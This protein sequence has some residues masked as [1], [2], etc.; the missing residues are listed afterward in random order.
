M[1]SYW[2]QQSF[3]HYDFIVIGAGIVGYNTALFLKAKQ[4]NARICILERGLLP[5][6]AS[7]KNAGFACMGSPTELLADLKT[8]H[9]ESVLQ[10]FE[11]RKNGLDDLRATF[12][13]NNIGYTTN[14]SYE[15]LSSEELYALNQLDFLNN[16]LHP[17]TKNPAFEEDKTIIT[18]SHFNG[19]IYKSAIKNNF[20]GQLHTGKLIK[21][22]MQ[23][24]LQ[25]GIELKT[26]C[27]VERLE[28]NEIIINEYFK[29]K[30]NKI[31]VCTNAFTKALLPQLNIIPGR[32]Q[33]LITKPITNLHFKGSFHFNEGYYYFRTIDNR[34]LFGGGRNHFFETETTT[35]MEENTAIINLLKTKLQEDILPT[36]PFEVDYC[37]TGIMGFGENKS[38]IINKIN[39][40]VYVGARCGGMGVAMGRQTAKRL[41]DLALQ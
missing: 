1:L 36:T 29:L 11:E 18:N 40:Y 8:Y 5:T 38:P 26:G 2:E 7:T 34:V 28:K 17:I 9:Q 30:A 39:E 6:G 10:L 12:G 4:P 31:F 24:A 15:L 14:G 13:D 23:M 25:N 33:V 16:F 19:N 37:W 35:L 3:I 22:L 32:G 21:C 27:T 41:V 20:E